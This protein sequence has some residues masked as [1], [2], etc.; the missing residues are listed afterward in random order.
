MARVALVAIA[1]ALSDFAHEAEDGTDI[2]ATDPRAEHN[3]RP[4]FCSRY[5][6]VPVHGR[7]GA[8]LVR[9]PEPPFR[10]YGGWGRWDF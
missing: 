6:N 9:R 5:R 2:A 1:L 3:L 10:M 7:A 8:P 4:H